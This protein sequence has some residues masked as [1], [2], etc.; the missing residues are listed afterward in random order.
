MVFR[1]FEPCS[2]TAH[3]VTCPVTGVAQDLVRSSAVC[4]LPWLRDTSKFTSLNDYQESLH[5]TT[6]LPIDAAGRFAGSK[7]ESQDGIYGR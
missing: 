6:H 1:S 7:K 5:A 3:S 4:S 2:C